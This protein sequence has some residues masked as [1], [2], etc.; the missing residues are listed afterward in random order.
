MEIKNTSFTIADAIDNLENKKLIINKDYQRSPGIWPDTA[1]SYFIDTIL[2]GFPYPQIYLYHNYDKER[3]KPFSEVI[4]G[5]Q[6]LTTILEFSRNEFKLTK[7]SKKYKGLKFEQL[8]EEMQEKFLKS[9]VE[10]GLIVSGNRS[11]VL[12]MFRRMNSYTTPLNPSEKR[13]ARF[14]GQFKWFIT[15]MAADI[16]PFLEE[17]KV[18]TPKQILRFFDLEFLT[19]ISLAMD[20]GLDTKNPKKLDEIYHKYDESFPNSAE[21]NIRITSFI[22]LLKKE[23]AALKGSKILT[24]NSLH[25]LFI[26]AT[27]L[28]Y[29]IPELEE[30]INITPIG[31]Y[32]VNGEKAL[33]GLE[34][35]S[36]AVEVESQDDNIKD[37][38]E[39]S[40][41]ST[42]KKPSR[43][44]KV[45]FMI[46]ALKGELA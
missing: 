34:M 23:F 6:R 7:E 21:F 38:V 13:N 39:A 2:E 45:K 1:K 16:S 33:R 44:V 8:D 26:A 35:L 14:Q 25:D 41:K 19:E 42:T 12:E 17:F 28:K 36:N 27:H 22:N 15:H 37:F 5:Q 32:Y 9:S 24:V 11:E 10:A 40:K 43:L 46:K 4:D 18:L 20:V 29:G 30:Q 3:K 31:V